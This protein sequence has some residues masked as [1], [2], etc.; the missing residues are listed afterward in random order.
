MHDIEKILQ[1]KTPLID[2]VIARY[3]PKS[4]DE[5]ALEYTLGKPRY[6]YAT[7]AV[8]KTIA[9]PAWELL[10]RGGK[11]WR[12]VLFLLVAEALGGNAEQ[13]I[14]LVVIPELVHNGTLIVDDTEDFSDLRRG[15]PCIHKLFGNDVAINAGNALYYI[16]LLSILKNK[17]T[18]GA[19]TVAALFEIYAQEMIN[20]SFGQGT[21]IAWHN[22]IDA[23]VSEDEYLQMCAYKTGTLARMAA[24]MAATVAGADA[25]IVEKLGRLAETIGI[26]FQIQDDILNLAATSGKNQFTDEYIGSDITEGKRSL[27]II[28]T[29]ESATQQDRQRLVDI[30]KM[31]TRNKTLISEAIEIVKKY[32]SIDYAKEKAR[33]LI[34][35][36]WRDVDTLLPSS[37]AKQKL[38]AFADFAIERDY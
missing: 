24:K 9:D 34:A 38:K 6:R 14:D 11:R 5:Q 31:H 17:H 22:D 28:K 19:E 25:E 27:I 13:C 10:G 18:L 37:K 21:D 23:S 20:I 36:A 7:D 32:D 1:E 2:D 30:L 35:Q 15:K 12:P 29:L 33:K 16:P 4:Y 8:N 3:M 26:V